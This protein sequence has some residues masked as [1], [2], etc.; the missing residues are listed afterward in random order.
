MR[1]F[2]SVAA[3]VFAENGEDTKAHAS[4]GCIVLAAHAQNVYLHSATNPNEALEA[5]GGTLLADD[6][7]ALKSALTTPVKNKVFHKRVRRTETVEGEQ[8]EHTL[9][10][11]RAPAKAGDIVERD[12]LPA[13]KF[14]GDP[15][16]EP[17]P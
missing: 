17:V 11:P 7:A 5:E 16:P 3:S 6:W 13:H 9:M 4:F 14:L 15:D 8:V 1:G 2:Y 10:V 12:W